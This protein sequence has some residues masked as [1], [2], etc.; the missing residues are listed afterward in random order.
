MK[1]FIK[2]AREK[3]GLSQKELA[4][5]IGVAP[6]TMHGYESRNQLSKS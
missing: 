2:E 5:L 3:A 6:N 4:E 1:F